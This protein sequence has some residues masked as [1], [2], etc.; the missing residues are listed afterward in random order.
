MDKLWMHDL[1]QEMAKEIVLSES[2]KDPCQ[3]SRLWFHQ[4]V[5]QVLK[6][7]K[8][9]NNI[10][11]IRLDMPEAENVKISGK[12]LE[13]MKKLRILMVGNANISDGIPYLSDEL[14]LIDWSRYPSSTLPPNFYPKRLVSLK[15]NHGRIKHLWK[16]V[17]IFRDL[18]FLSFSCCEYLSEI[19]NLSLI[20]QVESLS[21]DHCKSLVEVHESVGSLEKLVTLKLVFCSNL[22]TLPCRFK[23][24]SLRSL[25]LTGCSNIR[26]F[27]E[28]V[29]KMASVEEVLLE[30]TSIKALPQSTEYLI[31]L[32]VLLLDSCQK[33]E[34]LPCS[35]EKLQCL[36]S[37]SLSNCPRIRELPKLPL[38]TRFMWTNNCRSLQKFPNLYSTSSSIPG[39]DDFQRSYHMSFINCHNLIHKQV[40]DQIT[41]RLFDE[42]SQYE[43][44]LPGGTVPYWHDHHSTNGSISLEVASRF[45]GKPVE[46]F[47]GAV[48]DVNKTSNNTF[49]TGAFSFFVELAINNHKTLAIARTFDSLETSHVWLTKINFGNVLRPFLW[50]FNHDMHYWNQFVVSF[51]FS[52]VSP[53]VKLNAVLKFC[54]FH[55][56]CK[57]D[58]YSI[59]HT[60]V[61]I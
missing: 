39:L 41:N 8:E 47:F 51:G 3:R 15:M 60:L 38:N 19:P 12:A 32:E 9:R 14:R 44:M 58:G 10:E 5:L 54:G 4:D 2:P 27:P 1:I 30:G 37:L 35:I 34:H 36:V 46:L 56:S 53:N 26:N 29:E 11:C 42:A 28:I 59:D 43:I 20:P 55:I 16:G 18:K 17:K 45:N 40:Q 31:G 23:L 33:L 6:E 21:L 50:P 61:K 57:Q 24:K 52:Q 22:K 48:F 49:P 7:Q 25:L 13:K